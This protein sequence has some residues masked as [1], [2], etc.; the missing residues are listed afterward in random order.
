MT[1]KRFII[2]NVKFLGNVSQCIFVAEVILTLELTLVS[3]AEGKQHQAE[4]DN[5]LHLILLNYYKFSLSQR[6]STA[7]KTAKQVGE[8]LLVS[9]SVLKAHAL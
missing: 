7:A 5:E 8:L 2:I 6:L 9:Q 1:P 4:E 3:E